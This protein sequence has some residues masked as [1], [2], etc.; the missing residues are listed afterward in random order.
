[1]FW[2]CG[3]VVVDDDAA[4][5]IAGANDCDGGG[6]DVAAGGIVVADCLKPASSYQLSLHPLHLKRTK[7]TSGK[8]TM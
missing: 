1:M 4:E 2:G 5:P 6:V 8:S 3:V 7:R